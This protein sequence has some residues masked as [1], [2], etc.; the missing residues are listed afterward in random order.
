MTHA[1]PALSAGHKANF[2]NLLRAAKNQDLA[3]MQCTDASTGEPVATVCMVNRDAEGN[4]E[5]APV[6]KLFN[7]NPYEELLPPNI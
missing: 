4:V 2:N 1:S 6:A 7:T 3:L 5:F